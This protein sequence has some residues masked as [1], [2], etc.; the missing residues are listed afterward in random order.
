MYTLTNVKAYYDSPRGPI[1]A[2]DDVSLKSVLTKSS[3]LPAS[4]AA[5]NPRSSK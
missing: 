1:K 5:A 3:A 4:R 2:V